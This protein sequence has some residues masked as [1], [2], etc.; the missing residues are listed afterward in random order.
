MTRRPLS[1]WLRVAVFALWLAAC[2]LFIANSYR[3]VPP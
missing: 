2:V 3:C 1:P